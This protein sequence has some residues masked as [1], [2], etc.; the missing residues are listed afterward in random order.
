VFG[1]PSVEEIS[2]A[3]DTAAGDWIE[4]ARKGFSHGSPLSQK[5]T[6]RLIDMARDG[7]VANALRNEYRAVSWS[8]DSDGEFIEG[9]RAAL[10]DKDRNPKWR[11]ASLADVPP[12]L[13]ARLDTPAKGGDFN[14]KEEWS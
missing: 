3:L 7:D 1:Q 8:L 13:I 14:F 5:L 2:K 11:Y 4:K 12:E 6:Y 9:V 10:V